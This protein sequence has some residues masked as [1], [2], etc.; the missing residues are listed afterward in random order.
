MPSF[1]DARLKIDW[2][3]KHI[4]DIQKR[5]DRLEDSY[6][7]VIEVNPKFG[8][9]QI[10]YD[11]AD[12]GAAEDISLLVGDA[13]HNLKCALDYGWITTLERH[14]P[15]AIGTKTQ[16][17]VHPSRD[18]LEKSL[19]D[20]QKGFGPD[21]VNLMLTKIKPYSGGNDALW[22]VKTLN[23]LDKHRLLLPVITYTGIDAA[24]RWRMIEGNLYGWGGPTMTS[25]PWYIRVPDGWHVKN[26]GKPS[27][28]ILFDEGAPTHLHNVAS[29]LE[30]YSVMVLRSSRRW[31]ASEK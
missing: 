21:L 24:L 7:A 31:S 28:D 25:P 30:Y 5:I 22:D 13:L 19:T 6:S 9:N 20:P 26:K 18:S 1:A 23:I 8:Y 16:F 29:A 3:D 17:P 4:R 15:N 12:K 27:I 10:E 2:A 11:L 14:A